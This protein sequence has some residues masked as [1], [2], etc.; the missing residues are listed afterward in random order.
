MQP[1]SLSEGPETVELGNFDPVGMLN[2]W[3]SAFLAR[4]AHE[5]L[6][7]AAPWSAVARGFFP[8][9]EAAYS[10]RCPPTW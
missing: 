9:R 3:E 4:D 7:W 6:G 8:L 10:S 5:I 2:D 1:G